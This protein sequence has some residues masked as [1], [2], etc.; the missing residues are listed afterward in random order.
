MRVVARNVLIILGGVIAFL[1]TRG[2]AIAVTLAYEA[3]IG[4]AMYL[5]EVRMVPRG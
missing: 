5:V 4:V 1:A 3:A 2:A